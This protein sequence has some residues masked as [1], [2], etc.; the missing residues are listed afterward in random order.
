MEASR[1]HTHVALLQQQAAFPQVMLF[2]YHCRLLPTY[3]SQQ[4]YVRCKVW[5][6][7][8]ASV[9]GDIGAKVAG[10]QLQRAAGTGQ[11]R[12][13]HAR[14]ACHI[15]RRLALNWTSL[16]RVAAEQARGLP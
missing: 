10:S 14:H 12:Q 3:Q 7:T 6:L 11:A 1:L 9:G 8:L 13:L 4:A 16:H 2:G 5:V 15:R